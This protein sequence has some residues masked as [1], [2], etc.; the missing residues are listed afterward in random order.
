M[1]WGLVFAPYWLVLLL[2]II[3]FHISLLLRRWDLVFTGG[4][5]V[6]IALKTVAGQKVWL[7]WLERNQGMQGLLA[8]TPRN[9]ANN[10]GVEILRWLLQWVSCCGLWTL[11]CCDW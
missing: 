7:L 6:G 1:L 2:E 11:L 3:I 10:F 5:A 8:Y 4:F 9:N